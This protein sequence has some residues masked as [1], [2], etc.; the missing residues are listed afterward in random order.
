MR[1]ETQ[2]TPRVRWKEI[3]WQKEQ[4]CLL[5][6]LF[7]S[8][9]VPRKLEHTNYIFFLFFL[10]LNTSLWLPWI[11][12]Q[13]HRSYP[14]QI[15]MCFLQHLC[16]YPHD[17]FYFDYETHEN[18]F[19]RKFTTLELTCRLKIWHFFILLILNNNYLSTFHVLGTL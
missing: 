2:V 19:C 11:R 6:N 15:T 13:S 18:T 12:I 8:G 3:A 4:I 10:S 1:T 9:P 5:W 7:G 14:V 16:H 17:K